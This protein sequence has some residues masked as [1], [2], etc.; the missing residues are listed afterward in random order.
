MRF[1]TR[2]I[3]A[4]GLFTLLLSSFF[5]ILLAESL[6]ELEDHL[7]KSFLQ[8]EA[9]YLFEKY[10]GDVKSKNE[11]NEFKPFEMRHSPLMSTLFI[12]IAFL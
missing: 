10:V 7:V 11:K 9:D 1:K 4:F 6:T 5:G 2:L 3:L 8:Q 12:H